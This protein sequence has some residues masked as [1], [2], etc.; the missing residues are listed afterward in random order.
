LSFL[1]LTGRPRQASI[2]KANELFLKRRLT[3]SL[4]PWRRK[5]AAAGSTPLVR[6]EDFPT[7]LNQMRE[8]FERM[9]D[10]LTLAQPGRGA[11]NG[12]RWGLEVDDEDDA[13][14]VRAEAPGFEAGDFDL[15]S[16]D[17]QSR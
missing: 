5:K 2:V 15:M 13:V 14:V 6:H 1:L 16:F 11:A 8:E 7:F 3:M 12:W 17:D 4:I 10:R 9:F